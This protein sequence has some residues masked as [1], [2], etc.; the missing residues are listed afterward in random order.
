MTKLL[1]LMHTTG[2]R[3]WRW[4][5]RGGMTRRQPAMFH[6]LLALH[7]LRAAVPARSEWL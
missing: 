4:F 7:M 2:W 6:R 1:N 5:R 3:R